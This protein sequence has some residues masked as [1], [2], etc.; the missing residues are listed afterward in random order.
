MLIPP[1][2]A[3]IRDG[4]VRVPVVLVGGKRHKLPAKKQLGTW[5]P[6]EGEFELLTVDQ[7]LNQDEIVQWLATLGNTEEP[8]EQEERIRIGTEN[9]EERDMVLKLLRAYG[10]VIKDKGD[11]PPV[12]AIPIERHIDTQGHRPMML[13]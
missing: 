1:S 9:P 2:V 4:V 13:K 5:D 3:R 8:L 11:C 6:I 12:A 7:S 10:D